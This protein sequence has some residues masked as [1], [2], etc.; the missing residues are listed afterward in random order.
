M[1]IDGTNIYV[2]QSW[3]GDALMCLERG[4][5]YIVKPE[6][7]TGSDAT[8]LGTAV[9]A[10]I[11][12]VLGG[13]AFYLYE[14]VDAFKAAL[15]SESQNTVFNWTSMSS[16]SEMENYGVAMCGS[17]YENIQ[18]QVPRDGLIEHKFL[19]PLCEVDGY[20]VHMTGTMDYIV[21]NDGIWDWKTSARKY[22]QWE[23]QRHNVQSS[24]YALAAVKTG[25]MSET[26]VSFKFGVMTRSLKSDGQVVAVQR[27]ASHLSWIETQTRNVVASALRMG[28]DNPWPQVDQHNL[29]SSK[30]CPYWSICKGAHVSEHEHT[31]KESN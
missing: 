16:F 18:P 13:T 11:E 12:S 1:I 29:C 30:W 14:M 27:A 2:R 22:N 17:W 5:N 7:R 31:W 21:P 28:T 25:L 4:R 24:F 26:P 15:V 6:W 10:A 20:T 19:V 8:V 9:H 3:L 23:K